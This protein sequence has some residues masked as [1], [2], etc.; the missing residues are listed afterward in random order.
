MKGYPKAVIALAA[1]HFSLFAFVA[2]ARPMAFLLDDAYYSLTVAAHLA[3]GRG[4]TY[5]GFP[6]NG[7][8]PL[9]AFLM[10]P[11]FALVG[12][13]RML[14]LKIALMFGALCSTA[15]LFVLYRIAARYAGRAAGILAVM[16]GALSI[17]LLT[18]AACGLETTLH[19]LLFLLVV[20]FYSSRRNDLDRRSA[21]ILGLLLAALAY[22]RLDA[23]F[24]FFAIALDRFVVCRSAPGRAIADNLLVFVP[25]C[26]LL[27]PW[28]FWNA[29]TFGTIAQSSGAFHHWRGMESQG[30]DYALPGFALIALLKLVGLAVKLPLEPLTG[31]RPLLQ[32]PIALF[33]DRPRLDANVFVLLWQ[34]SP[35]LALATGALVLAALI[36][37]I[38]VGRKALRRLADFRPLTWVLVALAGAAIYYPL[39]MINYSMRHFFAYGLLLAA[40]LA[41]VGAALLRIDREGPIFASKRNAWLIALVIVAVFR[42]GPFDPGLKSGNPY[43]FDRLADIRATLPAGSSIGYTDCGF[44]GYFLPD[45]TVVNLDGILNFEAQRAMRENRMSD[46]LVGRKVQY[47][48]ALDNL[49]HEYARQFQT[50][51]MS[52][53]EPVAGSNFI[54]RVRAAAPPPSAA[55]P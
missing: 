2:L 27:A 34:K 20:N 23:C 6:T 25:A 35:V 15:S 46:Y 8:Q 38:L 19:A 12:P 3:E 11:V 22:A 28:F 54:Y 29:A 5:G 37:L 45:Y 52:V 30:I 50:D 41:A 44:Y 1:L 49:H 26:L 32:W 9:Y 4:I 51:M 7:F 18:H 13:H 31:Y 39:V 24:V 14:G 55:H 47:V 40:P 43:G 17:N 10:T 33:L 36:A 42:C 21:M 53:L 16:L 48:L